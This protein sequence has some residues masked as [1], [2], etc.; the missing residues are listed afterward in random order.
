MPKIF[1]AD[2]LP[3]AV[4]EYKEMLEKLGG[5]TP[6][7]VSKAGGKM[8]NQAMNA[9]KRHIGDDKKAEYEKL[10]SDAERREWLA[11]YI[12]N[13]AEG[14]CLGKNW[15]QRTSVSS[16]KTAWVW[17]TQAELEGPRWLNSKELAEIA[18]SSMA[19]RKHS[20]NRALS[21]AGVLEYR[22]EI[23]KEEM[24]KAIEE[25]ARLEQAAE[26]DPK[27]YTAMVEHMRNSK[28][29]GDEDTRPAKRSRASIAKEKA[30]ADKDKEKELSPEQIAFNAMCSHHGGHSIVGW[31]GY[32]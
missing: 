6:E 14:G 16:N 8:R 20:T 5:V 29:T 19:S 27:H 10:N 17:L 26:V 7:N 24:T 1:Q 13:P 11:E 2:E 9:M 28:N 12:L 18:I 23:R 25:G 32:A 31:S 22:H 3:K 21:D 30:A 15:T 4:A